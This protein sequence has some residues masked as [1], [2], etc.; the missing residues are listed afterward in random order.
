MPSIMPPSLLNPSSNIISSFPY[1]T[2]Y[3]SSLTS[4]PSI[5]FH[6]CPTRFLRITMFQTATLGEAT[7]A[8]AL[9]QHLVVNQR[10][11]VPRQGVQLVEIGARQQRR[12]RRDVDTALF[13]TPYPRSVLGHR[14][15]RRD[16]DDGQVRGGGQ[17]EERIRLAVEAARRVVQPAS[18]L[19]VGAGAQVH[20]HE[21]VTVQA[22]AHIQGQ[23][24][25]LPESVDRER[26]EPAHVGAELQRAAQRRS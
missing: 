23:R 24:E 16:V 2:L 25:S 3:K 10:L 7:K 8:A 12:L 21:R 14:V 9:Q 5:L 26:G 11:L 19:G 1:R 13:P 22:V 17:R 15:A 20:L 6:S 18:L 4:T